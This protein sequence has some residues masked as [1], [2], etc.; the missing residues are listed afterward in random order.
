MKEYFAEFF[1]CSPYPF[2][3]TVAEYVLASKDVIL[4]APTGAGKTKAALFPYLLARRL[5][6]DFPTKLL[7]CVP[8]RVLARSFYEDL[9]G[10]GQVAI[11]VRLQTG[12]HQGDPRLE[13][14]IIFATI[15]Q[16]LSS[17]LNIPYSLSS[18]QGNVNGGAVVSSYLVFDEFHLLDPDSTL[19]TTLEMLRMLK[20]TAPFLLMTATF[21]QEM[22]RRLAALVDARVVTVE[23]KELESIPTQRGKTRKFH[24][25]GALLTADEVLRRHRSRSIAI[26]N[27]VERAQ[28]LF[29]ALKGQLESQGR[30][31]TRVILLH[32]RFLR[33]DRRRKEDQVL[34]FFGKDADK[35]SSVILVATQVIEVGLDITCEAMHTEAAPA[36]AILQRAGRC[37]RFE[38][39]Q[40]EVYVYAVP[41]NRKGEPDFAPY[42]GSQRAVS[43]RT[44]HALP[45]FEGSN[46]NFPAEQRLVDLTHTEADSRMLDG[47]GQ[48][49]YAHRKKM[50]EAIERLD[51]GLARE[52][53]RNDD[54]ATVLVH[55]DPPKIETI[56]DLEGFSIFFGT[57]RG[58]FE[59]WHKA[60]L[61]NA[62]VLWLL[63]YPQ[64][65]KSGEEEDRPISYEWRDVKDQRDFVR[66]AI[67]VMNPV[68]AGYDAEVGFRFGP[69]EQFESPSQRTERVERGQRLRYSRESHQQHVDK[70]LNV[71]RL[72][73]A[74]EIAYPAARLEQKMGLPKGKLEETICIAIVCHDLGK[75]DRKWQAWAHEWQRRIGMP[76]AD[77]DMLAH[78]DYD[79]DN[80]SHRDAELKMADHRPPHAVE[81]AVA[82]RKV[83]HR[84]L[85][86]PPRDDPRIK[87]LKAV[88]TAIARHHSPSADSYKAFELH[89]SA[90]TAFA[91][92][93]EDLGFNGQLSEALEGR[94]SP[95][96]ISGLLVEPGVTDELLAYL[97]IVRALRLSDQGAT[98]GKE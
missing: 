95:Q 10:N 46:M 11:D 69:G 35:A 87:L 12:E 70:M 31:D 32:S 29:Q 24:R 89:P 41:V 13:G 14:E 62:E 71:Y 78:T 5:G 54:S 94:G 67:Y 74:G 59:Q 49:R 88:F 44:W 63:K 37:A 68:L 64:E 97:L 43:E 58:Q 77:A 79:S 2:Q 22:L 82:A 21:S 86:D 19:A 4:Q 23:Q 91:R 47:L 92:T 51:M 34:Q 80:P 90:A 17:F 60:G 48:T 52:L 72:R 56:Y 61:P 27:T 57:L 85:G 40:G 16:V 75:M 50:Q 98:G 33:S 65:R 66:S 84:L 38:N 83:I 73:F 8:M 96:S 26:C 55:P 39:E 20:S 42:L 15:D 7:Y 30:A 9:K 93:L 28:Q 53:I 18:R 36:N 1:S 81:G 76:A 45:L 3:Q 6:L 25:V